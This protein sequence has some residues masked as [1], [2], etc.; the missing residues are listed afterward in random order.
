MARTAERPARRHVALAGIGESEAGLS[1]R[2]DEFLADG[3]GLS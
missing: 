2:I 1:D 3:F